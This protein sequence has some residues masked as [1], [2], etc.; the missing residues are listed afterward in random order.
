MDLCYNKTNIWERTGMRM[1]DF[2]E[3]FVAIRNRQLFNRPASN[4]T[5]LWMTEEKQRLLRIWSMTAGR[6]Q[7]LFSAY[8]RF[9]ALCQMMPYLSGHAAERHCRYFLKTYFD[10]DHPMDV[11]HCEDVWHM[12]AEEL[13][14][15]PMTVAELTADADH[16]RWVLWEED[17]PP[18]GFPK[19]LC[20][21]LSADRLLAISARNWEEWCTEA[22]HI[23]NAFAAAGCCRVYV[24][25]LEGYAFSSPN[26]YAVNRALETEKKRSE[27]RFLLLSQTVRYLFDICLRRGWKMLFDVGDRAADVIA[28]LQYC[29][30]TVGEIPVFWMTRSLSQAERMFAM[31]DSAGE[32]PVLPLF[33]IADYPSDAELALA[34]NA[35][36]AR[37]PIGLLSVAGGGDL[38]DAAADRERLLHIRG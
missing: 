20:P 21:M 31:L 13:L 25:A 27:D 17:L 37:Y 5:E 32:M 11:A 3:D 29:T 7:P 38:I 28:L 14:H 4:L 9:C 33:R 1:P 30:K 35:Y 6:E 10:C 8:D 19:G 15:A 24:S 22:D 36:A 16:P 12:I 26:L 18:D 23:I 34:L 2:A